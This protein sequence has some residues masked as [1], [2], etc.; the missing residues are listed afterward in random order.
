MPDP[1]KKDKKHFPVIPLFLTGFL[2]GILLPNGIWKTG[3]HQ[4]T[5]SA[6]YLFGIASTGE[7]AGKELLWEV[8]KKNGSLFLMTA[9]TGLTSFGIPWAVILAVLTGMETGVLLT[10]S[11]LEFGLRGGLLGIS[12]LMPQ[13]LIYFPVMAGGLELVC[14]QSGRI[15]KNH[16]LY[17]RSTYRYLLK[18]MFFLG[19]F[20]IGILSEA[21][22]NPR[23]VHFVQ[24]FLKY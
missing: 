14:E 2:L 5:I 10:M 20:T 15:W 19:I 4:K 16:G 24:R 8:L 7:E 1:I 18:V 9:L 12:L 3:W 6:F 17:P 22:I 21:W 13:F 23:I 11:I